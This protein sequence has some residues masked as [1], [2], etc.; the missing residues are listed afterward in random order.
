MDIFIG[1]PVQ[2]QDKWVKHQDK[3][4][5]ILHMNQTGLAAEGL[6]LSPHNNC[7]LNF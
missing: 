2:R 3:V 6:T 7:L 4:D 1:K 5:K